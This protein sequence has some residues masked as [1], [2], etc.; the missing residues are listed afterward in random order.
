VEIELLGGSLDS[1]MRRLR[2]FSPALIGRAQNDRL[3]LNLRAVPVADEA[4]L[5]QILLA[6][7]RAEG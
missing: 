2:S 4:L 1:L 5:T 7:L 6:A 3:L